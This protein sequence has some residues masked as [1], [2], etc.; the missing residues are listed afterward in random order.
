MNMVIITFIVISG[1]KITL[2]NVS[3]EV[4]NKIQG[5]RLCGDA[6][7]G[8]V[9]R[10]KKPSRSLIFMRSASLMYVVR[11]PMGQTMLS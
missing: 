11:F 1:L 3:G 8:L 5:K 2:V 4:S 6:A 9:A 10:N 7:L